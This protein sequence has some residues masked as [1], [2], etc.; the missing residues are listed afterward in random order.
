MFMASDI[1]TVCTSPTHIYFDIE[2]LFLASK[3]TGAPFAQFMKT[4]DTGRF[5][6]FLACLIQASFTIAGPVS[7]Y[8]LSQL[9]STHEIQGLRFDGGRRS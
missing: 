6:G 3:I 8:K 2:R 9:Q 7:F 1:G 5:L 4:G